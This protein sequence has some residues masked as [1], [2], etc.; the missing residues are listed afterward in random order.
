MGV[1]IIRSVVS[2][3]SHHYRPSIFQ[4]SYTFKRWQSVHTSSFSKEIHK[5]VRVSSHLEHATVEI[6][7]MQDCS[8][9]R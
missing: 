4:S 3:M 9:L 5:I 7:Q 8:I 1:V 6:D 2:F